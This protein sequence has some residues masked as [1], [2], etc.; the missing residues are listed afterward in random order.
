[1]NWK[2][3]SLQ[4]IACIILGIEYK[5]CKPKINLPQIINK[6]HRKKYV[7][8]ATQSTS[9]CKYWNNKKGWTQTIDYLKSLDYDV[10]CID[11]YSSYGIKEQM[12]LIP[13][14]CIN[15]TGNKSLEDRIETLVNCEFFIGLGSG[16][17][18]LAWAC[19]KPVIMI[20]GFSDPKSEFYTPYR[21]HNKNVCNSC[22]NDDSLSFD[23]NNWMWC[24]RNKNFECSKKITFEMVKE[25]IDL[26]IKDLQKNNSNTY[27]LKCVHILVDTE[28]EREK[29]SI[30]SMQEINNKIPY[31][32]CINKKYEGTDWK[33]V[34]PITGFK[35]HGAGHY[36]AFQS[37]KKAILENFTDD[38]DGL[39]IFEA[40]CVLKV[41]MDKFLSKVNE[42]IIFCEKHNLPYLSFG[43]RV[44]N[45]FLES[46]CLYIDKDH[47][48]FII[49][50]KIILAH[51]I[52]ITKKYRNY[53][54][55]QLEKSWD[56]PDLWFNEIFKNFNMGIVIDEL[57]Y[58]TYGFSMIDNCFKWS[59]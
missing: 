39:L 3:Y 58:Q 19:N 22:W 2:K 14:N 25:K 53:V 49:T 55:E 32:K 30:K 56:S 21:V 42:A 12:N 38:L 9:Q 20:S 48:N 46:N 6:S 5:E 11:K 54:F 4:E 18:W 57:A 1:M 24:P 50:D 51:C 8:I 41:S 13:Y 29:L 36:G 34:S 59:K 33:N 45:G 23:K 37:F 47:P 28:S 15:D 7:C 43:P 16:L 31:I 26:C 27:N 17:S 44:V 40:D 52:L 35:N 10:I